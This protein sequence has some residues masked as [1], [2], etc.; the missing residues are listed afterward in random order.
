[1]IRYALR[2]DQKHQFDGWFR[3]S[4][5]FEDLR[6]NG[7]V[8][9]VYCG[10]VT[11]DR[12]LMAPAIPAERQPAQRAEGAPGPDAAIAEEAVG[13]RVERSL[14]ELRQ[15]VDANSDYVGLRFVK[16]ARAMHEGRSPERA[17]HGEARADEAR[18]LIED[19]VKVVP[20]PFRAKQR[21]T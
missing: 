13:T 16:E 12:A 7:Q 10:S 3:S 15:Y 8:A 6:D 17:I 5:G 1:M 2:C 19:G 9:C 20:L 11:V 18:K 4:A 21:M 14:A